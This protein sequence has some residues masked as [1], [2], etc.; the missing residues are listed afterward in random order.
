MTQAEAPPRGRPQPTP[1]GAR[2]VGRAIG[3]LRDYRPE[4]FGALVSLLLVSAAN[5]AAPQMV[6]VAIDRGLRPTTPRR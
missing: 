1:G 2:A 4:S 6:R 3:Y 5:L